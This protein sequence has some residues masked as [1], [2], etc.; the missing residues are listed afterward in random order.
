[1]KDSDLSASAG[2]VQ[3]P[4]IYGVCQKYVPLDVSSKSPC[5]PLEKGERFSPACAFAAY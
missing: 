5:P 1:M 3:N 4:G 2:L